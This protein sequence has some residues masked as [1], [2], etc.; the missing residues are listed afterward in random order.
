MGQ[1]GLPSAHRDVPDVQKAFVTA[2]EP[3]VLGAAGE[4]GGGK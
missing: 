1:D 3:A 2:V 4:R